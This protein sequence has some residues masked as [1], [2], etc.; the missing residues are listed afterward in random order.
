MVQAH[1]QRLLALDCV[2]TA[3][4]LCSQLQRQLQKTQLMKVPSAAHKLVLARLEARRTAKQVWS[5]VR[6]CAHHPYLTGATCSLPQTGKACQ[7]GIASHLLPLVLLCLLN[8]WCH[9]WWKAGILKLTQE[10][11]SG[12]KPLTKSLQ[13]T[14]L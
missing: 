7:L 11:R 9:H 14:H 12:M 13:S 5:L 4:L 6:V 10:P 1:S 8:T 2:M 3:L